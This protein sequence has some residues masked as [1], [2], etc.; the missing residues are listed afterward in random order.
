MRDK[1]SIK[2]SSTQ[3]KLEVSAKKTPVES[4]SSKKTL[5]SNKANPTDSGP[6]KIKTTGVEACSKSILRLPKVLKQGS[7]IFQ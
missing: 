2:T 4:L 3:K 7:K 1:G 5:K 6:A